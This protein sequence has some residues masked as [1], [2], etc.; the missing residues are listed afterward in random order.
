MFAS[1]RR[2]RLEREL[3]EELARRVDQGFTQEVSD[4]SGFLSYELLDCGEGEFVT[5]SMFDNVQQAEASREL[6]QRWADENLRDLKPARIEALR[7]EVVV[8]RAAD[9][10]L[11]PAHTRA[12]RKFGSIRRYCWRSGDAADLLRTVD[13]FAEQVQ[14]VDGFEAYHALDGGRGE[15]LSISLFRDQRSAEA[16]DDQALQF[17]TAHLAPFGIER[18]EVLGGEV[19]ASRARSELLT[20]A[21]A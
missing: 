17:V 4:R 3:T 1:I 8:G 7:G 20:P 10:I 11:E 6:A 19:L 18:C 9:G 15:I 21:Y 2:Y 13:G 5:I 16:S 14:E 12:G